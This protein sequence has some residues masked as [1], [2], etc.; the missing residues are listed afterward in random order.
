MYK[1]KYTKYKTKLEYLRQMSGGNIQWLSIDP[2]SG[3]L[4]PYSSTHSDLI[5]SAFQAGRPNID[6]DFGGRMYTISF[7][8]MLQADGRGSR[9]SVVR[10][11]DRAESGLVAWNLID[12][13]SGLIPYSA[14]N[15]AI[16]ERAFQAGQ[17]SVRIIVNSR[18]YDIMLLGVDSSFQVSDRGNA[19]P[20]IRVL[21]RPPPPFPAAPLFDDRTLDALNTEYEKLKLKLDEVSATIQDR[22]HQVRFDDI[23]LPLI[24][25]AFEAV[26]ELLWNHK[27]RTKYNSTSQDD[28]FRDLLRRG[29]VPSY[30]AQVQGG[31][32]MFARVKVYVM[33]GFMNL[34]HRG[35][36]AFY[37][38]R[39]QLF[40][41][42]YDRY[43]RTEGLNAIKFLTGTVVDLDTKLSESTTLPDR[44]SQDSIRE[45]ARQQISEFQKTMGIRDEELAG[46]DLDLRTLGEFPVATSHADRGRW[47][48]WI[49]QNPSSQKYEVYLNIPDV[50]TIIKAV[51]GMPIMFLKAIILVNKLYSR[52]SSADWEAA[53]DEF[54]EKTMADGC[55]NGKIADLES[56]VND[57]EE[58]AKGETIIKIFQTL[59]MKNQSVFIPLLE[60]MEETIAQ[61]WLLSQGKSGR[62]ER[63]I[64]RPI[65]LDDVRRYVEVAFS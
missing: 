23:N 19:I 17:E 9:R 2:R 48:I 32:S 29:N 52:S 6:I 40:S 41:G 58:R 22:S 44:A 16:I 42:R 11:G 27:Y 38:M 53:W 35:D 12:Q 1:T 33:S 15:S 13:R 31:E 37:E 4:Q 50:N 28:Q 26:W 39:D 18:P 56:Y 46:R 47:P 54:F 10:S 20:I 21:S 30:Y 7:D 65:T 25:R 43:G 63:D 24:S 59:E 57:L 61:L 36:R 62:D 34:L 8:R 14:H 51:L 3:E 64:N 45:L 60:D 55:L 5:E 49:R